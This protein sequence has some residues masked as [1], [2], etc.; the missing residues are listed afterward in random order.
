M[1]GQLQSAMLSSRSSRQEVLIIDVEGFEGPLD[2]L[3]ELARKQ[4]V[5]LRRISVLKLVQ[6]YAE[7]IRT[8]EN[9]RIELAAEYLVMAAWLALIKSRLLLPDSNPDS[10]SGEELAARLAF[11]L[12][13]LDAMRDAARKLMS[14]RQLGAD[15]FARGMPERLS[16]IRQPDYQVS[17]LELMQAYAGLNAGKDYRPYDTVR[18]R[19][20]AVEEAAEIIVNLIVNTSNW[21]TL[22]EFLPKAWAGNAAEIRSATAA[23]FAAALE[24]ARSGKLE[25]R[26]STPFAPIDVRGNQGLERG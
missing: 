25:M 1:S 26:Q 5:D 7:F 14:R 13:R 18:Q 22:A 17:I 16:M 9:I 3:L 24:L 19:Y 11:R 10:P 23:I 4:K 20:M 6:Q 21:S 12:R 15:F 2:L 8:A